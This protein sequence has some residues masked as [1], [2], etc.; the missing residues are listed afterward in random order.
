MSAKYEQEQIALQND[1]VVLEAAVIE[2][3]S[4]LGNVDRFIELT[5]EYVGA[6]TLTSGIVNALIDKIV[7]YMPEVAYGNNRTQRVEILYNG[8]GVI[9]IAEENISPDSVEDTEV[10]AVS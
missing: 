10:L 6:K 5:R 2:C 8:V 1:V 9:D 3:E 7:V 4:R